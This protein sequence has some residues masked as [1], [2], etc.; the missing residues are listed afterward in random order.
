MRRMRRPR[1]ARPPERAAGADPA[2][3]AFEAALGALAR[4]ER[5]VAEVRA[6]L[7]ARGF[8]GAAIA[9]ALE[10]LIEAGQLDDARFAAAYAADKRELRGWGSERIREALEAREVGAGEIAAALASDP[11]EAQ[12]ERGAELLIARRADLSDEASR[13]R[14]HAYLV[15]RGYGSEVAYEA[16]RRAERAAV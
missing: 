6:W 2:E 13:G 12:A 14:A 5:S 15:R 16:V 4:K 1:S 8:H 10:R 7:E 11:D 9:A 3:E